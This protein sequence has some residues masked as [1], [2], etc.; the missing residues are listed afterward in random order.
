[1]RIYGTGSLIL[2]TKQLRILFCLISQP[3]ITYYR[4]FVNYAAISSCYIKNSISAGDL[5]MAGDALK[6]A[7]VLYD[8]ESNGRKIPAFSRPD[9]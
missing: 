8:Y 9:A 7:L 5:F 1:M 3:Q 2:E 4:K 6:L